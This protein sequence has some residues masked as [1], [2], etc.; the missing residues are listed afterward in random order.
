MPY[1]P[2][3]NQVT[4]MANDKYVEMTRKEIE[5][6]KKRFPTPVAEPRPGNYQEALDDMTRKKEGYA[7]TTRSKMG[8]RF[9]K[10]GRLREKINRPDTRHGVMDMPNANISKFRGMKHGGKVKRFSGGGGPEDDTGFGG[11]GPEDDTVD[12]RSSDGA[13][14]PITPTAP[15]TPIVTKEQLAKSGLSLRDYMNKQQGKTRRGGTT[16]TP[17]TELRV[18]PAEVSTEDKTPPAELKPW[19]NEGDTQGGAQAG[20][21]YPVSKRAPNAEAKE[22]NADR[23]L[24]TVGEGVGLAG[25][26][27]GAKRLLSGAR[28]TRVANQMGGSGEG[29][30]RG[31]DRLSDMQKAHATGGYK[32]GGKVKTAGKKEMSFMQAKGAPKFMAARENKESGMKKSGTP[33]EFIQKMMAKKADK[34]F[35]K[36]GGIESRG[37]T[38]GTIVKMASGGAVKGFAKGGGIESRGKTRCKMC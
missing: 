23:L 37:K 9:A 10:G 36:G 34:K 12:I 27:G 20:R 11:G 38:K 26:V 5:Q 8:E 29:I 28:M 14:A 22:A 2:K 24:N 32:T 30:P 31:W 13:Q 33:P 25:V 19:R 18:G 21:V 16:P 6:L 7:P 4:K 35:A 17:R 1:T 3:R 15:K